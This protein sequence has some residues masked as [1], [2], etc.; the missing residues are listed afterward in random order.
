M[1][2]GLKMEREVR[3]QECLGSIFT[4]SMA[5]LQC[6]KPADHEYSQHQ[7]KNDQ[8]HHHCFGGHVSDKIKGVFKGHHH[9]QAPPAVAPVHHS[10]NAN[11]CK[12]AGS[13]KKKEHHKNKEGG[14]FHKIKDAFS[15]HSSDSS[16][17]SDNEGHK[18][19]H[20]KK[21]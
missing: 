9:G 21:Y 15:D 11:H 10:A 12:P 17:D 14:L 6:N 5:S 1:A 20:N 2:M 19:N 16:S 7:Q 8:Q 18:A 13:K 3:T 4:A